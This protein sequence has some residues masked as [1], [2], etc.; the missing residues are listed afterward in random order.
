ML[1]MQQSILIIFGKNYG[2]RRT[3]PESGCAAFICDF[4][5]GSWTTDGDTGASSRLLEAVTVGTLCKSSA[6][7]LHNK[8]ENFII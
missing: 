8:W 5:A 4:G 2:A 7:I 3:P 6:D 1:K